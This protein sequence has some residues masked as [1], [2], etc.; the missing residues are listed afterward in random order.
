MSS[1]L[2]PPP[3][4]ML[5]LACAIAGLSLPLRPSVAPSP[6]RS[7]TMVD[8]W[9][10]TGGGGIDGSTVLGVAVGLAGVLGGVGI[11]AFTESAGKRNEELANAQPCVEC[12]GKKVG[13]AGR[14][15]RGG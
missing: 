11:I 12:K 6:S 7:V 9:A 5:S 8:P 4:A 14:G 13:G 2:S 10:T 3:A 15:G 1:L